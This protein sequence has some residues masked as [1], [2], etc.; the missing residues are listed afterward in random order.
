MPQ[1]V[2]S[3]VDYV[4]FGVSLLI[5]ACIG[6]YSACSGGKQKTTK[7]FL[8]GNRQMGLFPVT[9]SLVASF[10]SA[11]SVLGLP[12]E[13]YRFGTLYYMLMVATIPAMILTAHLYL[14]ILYRLKLTSAYEV[15]SYLFVS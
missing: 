9:M 11:I 8:M 13:I 5:A 6:V 10:V 1:T 3:V 14:P 12:S 15:K 2:F 7:E 4:V